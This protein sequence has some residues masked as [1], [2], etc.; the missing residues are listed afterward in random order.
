VGHEEQPAV[1]L[2]QNPKIVVLDAFVGGG[3]QADQL[4]TESHFQLTEVLSYTTGRHF[5]KTGIN[6]PDFSRRGI[7]NNLN[8]GG[9]FYFSS[10]AD[11]AQLRP[12]S[13]TQQRGNGHLVFY[14]N[15]I[16]GFVQD[17]FHLRRNLTISA[18][19][20][21]DWQNYFHDNNNFAP[22]LSFLYLPFKN[23]RTIIRGGVGLFYDRVSLSLGD[24]EALN[25]EPDDLTTLARATRFTQLPQRT[26]TNFASDGV[27]ILDGPRTFRN[28]VSGRLRDPRSIRWSLQLDHA[29]TKNLT[30][31]IGYLDRSTSNDLLIEPRVRKFNTLLLHSVGRSQYQEL[32]MLTTYTS[33]HLGNWTASYTWSRAQGDLNTADN[34]LSDFPTLVVR[35]NEYGPLPWDV[36][37]RFLAFGQL[38]APFGL[39]VSPSVEIRSGFPFSVVNERLDF[40]G[41]RDQAGRFPTF[42]SID[43]QVTKDFTIPRFI[44]KFDGKKAR[45]GVAVFN[46]TNHFNPRDVQNNLGSLQFG[47]FFNSLGTSVRGKFEIDY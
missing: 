31:R 6:V 47:Q 38:K 37:H 42:V 26:V 4:R 30:A 32:Q 24:F 43:A 16:G 15:V 14:E 22:R 13:F 12:Y 33:N 40:V 10:L 27:S 20:R 2:S 9:T 7:N 5:I 28:I 34:F 25:E 19:L 46:M 45:L 36:P 44:P 41:P 17:D 8:S 3:A 39:T 11:Y 29:F 18:G 1:S 21:Y 23:G 35:P